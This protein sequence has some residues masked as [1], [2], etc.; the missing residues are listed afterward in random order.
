MR[1]KGKG[2]ICFVST[3][4]QKKGQTATIRI[5]DLLQMKTKWAFDKPKMI[6]YVKTEKTQIS[7]VE[8]FRILL[9]DSVIITS[10]CLFALQFPLNI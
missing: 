3:S 9:D 8:R 10:F 6:I 4:K 7:V 2:W 1:V 5:I